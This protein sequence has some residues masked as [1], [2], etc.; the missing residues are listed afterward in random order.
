MKKISFLIAIICLL[1]SSVANAA[2]VDLSI[3]QNGINFSKDTLI[4][5]DMV[6]IYSK[7]RN[8]GDTDVSGYV[9]FYQG[10]IPIGNSQAISLRANG[11]TEEVFVDFVIPKATFNIRAE[12]QGT[13]P[14]DQNSDNNV[15]M[16]NLIEPVF[17]EDRDGTP[18]DNDNCPNVSNQN[19]NDNDNDG[20]GDACDDDDDND[21]LNDSLEKEL[22]TNPNNKDSDGDGVNDPNDAFPLDPSKTELPKIVEEPVIE[23]VKAPEEVQQAQVDSEDNG[24]IQKIENIIKDTF[25]DNKDETKQ[26]ED[27]QKVADEEVVFSFSQSAIFKYSRISWNTFNFEAV[28][29]DM[30]GYRF[31]WD[32][33][34]G[35]TSNRKDVQHTYHSY[36]DFEVTMK[37]TGPTHESSEDKIVISIPFLTLH[38]RVIGAIIG[39]LLVLIALGL[40]VIAKF[41]IL[42]KKHKN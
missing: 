1:T 21:G 40:G 29:P 31:E 41:H 7:I 18:D 24:V 23:A 13:D 11:A 39:F 22:G 2:L 38:N 14:Q 30:P 27:G 15:S 20:L 28:S 6:R 9:S 4:A 10:D 12:I 8:I 35:V 26:D 37:I 33:G 17:D 34:D 5:G 19:Q 42:Q 36:G 25:S 3:P 16:T 32:F